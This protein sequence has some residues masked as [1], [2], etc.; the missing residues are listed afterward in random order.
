MRLPR[1]SSFRYF[2][3]VLVLLLLAGCSEAGNLPEGQDAAPGVAG[4]QAVPSEGRGLYSGF[5][6]DRLAEVGWPNDLN[7]SYWWPEATEGEW[8]ILYDSEGVPYGPNT[9]YH[10]RTRLD[11]P[12]L[13]VTDSTMTGRWFSMNRHERSK[14]AMFGRWLELHDL[15]HQDMV[16]RLQYTPPLKIL[17]YV[18][19]ELEDY[20]KVTGK[21]YWVTQ[22]A[23]G[24]F[25]AYEP[26]RVLWARRLAL[27]AIRNGVALAF[28]DMKC[29]GLTPPWLRQGLASY[30]AQEGGVLQ[31]FANE[32]RGQRELLWSPQ[33]VMQHIDP[34]YDRENGRIA[35]YNA[36][37]MTWNLAESYGWDKIQALLDLMEQGVVFEDAVPQA[38]QVS[39]ERLLELLDPRVYGEPTLAGSPSQAD[40]DAEGSDAATPDDEGQN[41]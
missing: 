39:A 32:F 34:L 2:S 4:S 28:L 36:F 11:H 29:H 31:G 1:V 9:Y 40:A 12:D 13:S 8:G 26:M 41:R 5:S 23:D 24:P 16:D 14:E 3:T 19:P 37:L 7:K 33:Q 15:A 17:L 10:F 20:K 25:I 18:A 35:L 6:R 22:V 30:L 21:D 27:H 38:Y